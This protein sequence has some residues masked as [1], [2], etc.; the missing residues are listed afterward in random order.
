MAPKSVSG[1]VVNTGISCGAVLGAE[2][3]PRALGAADPVALHGE[4]AL[5]PVD[6][7]GHVVQ[8]ALGVVGDAQEPLR[9]LAQLHLGAAALAAPVDDLLVGEHGLVLGAPVDRRLAPLGQAALEEAQEEPLGPAVVL[10]IAG[11]D[12]GVPVDG[13]A[14]ALE[15]LADARDVAR[16]DLGRRLAGADGGVLGRQ[17][18]GV[19]AHRVE[20]RAAHAPAVVRHHVA[21]RV[22]L[23]VAHVDLARGVR[24]HLQHVRLGPRG[25]VG[26]LAVAR[27]RLGPKRVIAFPGRSATW[28]RRAR[29]RTSPAGFARAPTS[30]RVSHTP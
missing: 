30:A 13:E 3:H 26:T 22:V 6:Q 15:L 17:A 4:H 16:R 20:D 14:Q 23:D 29:G 24:E 7:L 11:G 9:Q 18:E 25:Q 10:G 2:H 5:G 27:H 28:T 19:V 1:R 12:L 8:Q 21:H